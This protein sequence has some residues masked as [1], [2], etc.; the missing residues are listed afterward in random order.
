V[1]AVLDEDELPAPLQQKITEVASDIGRVVI[2][3][4]LK[5]TAPRRTWEDAVTFL[6]ETASRLGLNGAELR[7]AYGSVTTA[8]QE[9]G[10][11][12]NADVVL[13]SDRHPMGDPYVEGARCL[14]DVQAA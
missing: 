13:R 11:L 1:V 12:D 6:R 3:R 2:V 7:I 14:R 9:V 5:T 8:V 10:R 4:V